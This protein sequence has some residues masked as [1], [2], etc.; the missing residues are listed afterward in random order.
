MPSG[1]KE[2]ISRYPVPETMATARLRSTRVLKTRI[3]SASLFCSYNFFSI[4][5]DI[6]HR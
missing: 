6:V 2:N 1:K 3:L 5:Y 4:V